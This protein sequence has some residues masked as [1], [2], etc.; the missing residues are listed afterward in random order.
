MT[1]DR[2]QDWYL[3][4][5]PSL[6]RGGRIFD[7]RLVAL[8]ERHKVTLHLPKLEPL[9]PL[10]DQ[11][12]RQ[13]MAGV[14]VASIRGLPSAEQLDLASKYLSEGFAVFIY[15]PRE[16][17]IERADQDRIRTFRRHWTFVRAYCKYVGHTSW[18]KL[19]ETPQVEPPED[20]APT[21][22]DP[23][24]AQQLEQVCDFELN[25]I[26]A[27]AQPVAMDGQTHNG[28]AS[29]PQGGMGCYLR[30]D[31]WAPIISGGSYG[32]T[33][34]VAQSLAKS[35]DSFHSVMANHMDLLDELGLR[36]TVLEPPGKDG[37]E[38]NIM[39]ANGHYYPLLREM[40][41]KESPAYIYERICLGSYLG[42]L[43]SQEFGIP[44]IVEYNGSEIS[45]M[46]SFS[47]RGYI[48]ESLYLKA[49]EAAFRQATII[50]VVSEE[51]RADLLRRNVDDRKILVNPNG[52]SPEDYA[53]PDPTDRAALRKRFGWTDEHR[54]IGFTGTFGGW[55][56]V[57]VLAS[58]LPQICQR[59][60]NARFLLIG[61]GNYRHLVDEAI[62]T[63]GLQAKVHMAGRTTQREGATLL[64]ACDIFVSPHNSHMV[65][66]KFFGSPTKIFE[67][68]SMG[69]AIVASDLEQIGIV[70]SPAISS[71]DLPG[72]LAHVTDER[73]VLC[74]PGDLDSFVDAA[75]ALVETPAAAN[76]LGR[77][78]RDAVLEHYS[79]DRHV[80]RIWHFLEYGGTPPAF[81]REFYGRDDKGKQSAIF[82]GDAYKDEVQ[83]QWDNEP[84]GS[85]YV[86]D[87][88]SNT[89]EWYLEAEAY[90]Y[91][92]YAPWMHETMEFGRH[93]GERV[94]EIG[95]GMGTDL[96]QFA[97]HGA[98]VTDFDLSSGH[99][100][101][102]QE[103][104]RLRGLKGEFIH[105]D[106]EA[107]PFEN[108]SFDV[109]YSNG[110]I[111]HTPNTGRVIRHMFRVLRPGGRAI[112][113][114]YA[115]NSL[116]YWRNI[117]RDFGI[118]E[119]QL[120][121][122]SIGETLS[123]HAE[124]SPSGALP[125]VKVYTRKRLRHMFGM[126]DNV[127]ISQRQITA[128]EMP[129]QLKWLPL[130][131]AGR[132]FGWNLIVKGTKPVN[133]TSS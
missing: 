15:F 64:G 109:V 4:V 84:A 12:D 86:K 111:H 49:E 55:H 126:F 100:A 22:L 110:V 32:H 128:P 44:Y 124:L 106:G 88:S 59:A 19:M 61:D 75:I 37:N 71:D 34:Y 66:S 31:F 99:L 16:K 10:L 62:E 87:A 96:A 60:P 77:N 58:A 48:H 24:S 123:Q 76:A 121:L 23:N 79:W 50:S 82:T 38:L 94:L 98:K 47:G 78:G 8:E 113:M 131:L 45:M 120:E 43:L 63:H 102:A 115:Q 81:T 95:G 54:V 90:R 127:T 1:R 35:S 69:G 68:M 18:L 97:L 132:L 114:V 89:L 129:R 108:E 130:G 91:G 57:D 2:T 101:H 33:C 17:A 39:K 83:N 65:D 72:A 26:I 13:A 133:A 14:I 56:G 92:E 104:F 46:R 122:Y 74:P 9:E 53:P 30:L 7:H 93:A 105:G 51:V 118:A 5:A 52:A 20:S 29:G 125:L 107:L 3:Y 6:D 28:A 85:H 27:D 25:Q 117:V 112:V 73:A 119:G 11:G 67:Y 116:H 80:E 42:A 40:F 70:L 21:V 36:Q 41:Q 103:N